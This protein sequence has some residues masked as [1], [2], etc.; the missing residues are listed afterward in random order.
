MANPTQGFQ[1]ARNIQLSY[2]PAAPKPLEFVDGRELAGQFD[3]GAMGRGVEAGLAIGGPL[4]NAAK[5]IEERDLKEKELAVR[6]IQAEGLSAYRQAVYGARANKINAAT[7]ADL[8][9]QTWLNDQLGATSDPNTGVV[10][11]TGDSA[12]GNLPQWDT[13]GLFPDQTQPGAL[14]P[15]P[16]SND[17]TNSAEPAPEPL[18]QA[19]PAAQENLPAPQLAANTAPEEQLPKQQEPSLP[20]IETALPESPLAPAP[21]KL[22]AVVQELPADKQPPVAEPVAPPAAGPKEPPTEQPTAETAAQAAAPKPSSVVLTPDEMRA[23]EAKREGLIAM[24]LQRSIKNPDLWVGLQGKKRVTHLDPEVDERSKKKP[25]EDTMNP[26][27]NDRT[28]SLPVDYANELG[29]PAVAP[30][31]Y[32]GLSQKEKEKMMVGAQKSGEKTLEGMDKEAQNSQST[33]Q[34]VKAFLDDNSREDNSLYNKYAPTSIPGVPGRTDIRDMQ[35]IAN[36]LIPTMRQ[37]T[38]IS[39]VT[40]MDMQIFKGSTLSPD[41]PPEVN[42]RI[43]MGLISAAQDAQEKKSFFENYL[44]GHGNLRFAE[45]NWQE[46]LDANPIYDPKSTPAEF[47]LNKGRLPWQEYFNG[48][49]A[50]LGQANAGT[51]PAPAAAPAMATTATSKEDGQAN[52]FDS[53]EEVN[54]KNKAYLQRALNQKGDV[55]LLD[56]RKVPQP[57]SQDDYDAIPSKSP[58]VDP[59]TGKIR[60]KV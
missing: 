11:S 22:A 28:I 19:A 41:N 17:S 18:A 49:N 44:V 25:T 43:A 23:I 38:G 30:N 45:K 10:A 31:P 54:S 42:R 21:E 20:S 60:L 1:L 5:L 29:I 50:A 46:Y 58:Y 8:E 2:Q 55:I 47:D 32:Y 9:N 56:T 24:G 36:L 37:G 35:R 27:A 40:N 15:Q 39:R 3:S 12:D 53:G 34:N 51:A 57:K 16:D 6:K 48:K 14:A 26:T 7:Q 13:S 52:Y 59:K 33:I 4:Q